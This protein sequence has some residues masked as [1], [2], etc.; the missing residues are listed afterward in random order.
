MRASFLEGTHLTDEPKKCSLKGCFS[1]IHIFRHRL[2]D[3][4]SEKHDTHLEMRCSYDDLFASRVTKAPINPAPTIPHPHRVANRR[5]Q[6]TKKRPILVDDIEN[7]PPRA[8]LYKLS[9]KIAIAQ[10][11]EGSF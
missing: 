9:V 2:Y 10:K 7:L 11:A 3:I 8:L 6:H 5:S 4:F 1:P